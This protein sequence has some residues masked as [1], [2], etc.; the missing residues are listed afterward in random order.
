M[1]FAFLNFWISTSLSKKKLGEVS[2]YW[3][4][5]IFGK[6]KHLEKER[7]NWEYDSRQLEDEYKLNCKKTKQKPM[8]LSGIFVWVT[9][10]TVKRT[11]ERTRNR[12]L[13]IYKHQI[14]KR[15]TTT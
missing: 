13:D 9:R 3:L 14:L 7:P 12:S 10:D 2:F 5:L 11:D 1:I 4:I 8:P 6:Q 15:E